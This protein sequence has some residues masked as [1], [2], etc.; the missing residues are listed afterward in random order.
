M[1]CRSAL[2]TLLCLAVVTVLA[3]AATPASAITY[4]ELDGALHPNVGAVV[5]EVPAGPWANGFVFDGGKTACSSGTLIAPRVFLIAGHS[6]AL[7]ESM[8]VTRVWVTFDP[9]FIRGESKLIPGTMHANPD[10]RW[11]ASDPNDIAVIT[12]DRPVKGV[13]LAKLPTAGLLDQMAAANGLHDQPFT[14]VGYGMQERNVGGG[15]P[16]YGPSGERRFTTSTFDALT[17]AFLRLCMNPALG[18]GGSAMFDSGGPNF[19][20]DSDIIAATTS[21]GD[22]VSRAMGTA[23]RLDTPAARAYLAGFAEYGLILP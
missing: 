4:G 11:V 15:T 12:F 13:P 19:I 18:N 14:V 6:V 22:A 8:G 21:G 10:F 9:A 7:L 16:A 3:V 5:A 1:R 20:G 2:T 17:P 23:C